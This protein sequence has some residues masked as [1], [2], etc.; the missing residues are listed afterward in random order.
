MVQL[1]C[2]ILAKHTT[3]GARVTQ[4]GMAHGEVLTPVF[5]PVGTRAGV[6]NMTPNELIE[7]GSQMILGGNTYHT[8]CAPGIE[9]IKYERG[10]H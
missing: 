2:K 7:A 9:N 6:N 8:L 4:L 5:M 3:N 10:I 1:T